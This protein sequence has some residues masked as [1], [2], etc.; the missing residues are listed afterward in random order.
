[1][2]LEGFVDLVYREDDGS[3]AI[4]DYK[5][6]AVPAGG[7]AS[8]VV[9]YRPQ[10]DAYRTA[11]AAATGARVTTTLLFLNPTGSAAVPV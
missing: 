11:L 2:V 10:L 8:R 5:T 7:V 6:D 3:L 4:V 9:Y 1:V